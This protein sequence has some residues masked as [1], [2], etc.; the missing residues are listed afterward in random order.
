MDSAISDGCFLSSSTVASVGFGLRW[1][2]QKES[3]RTGVAAA[4]R[5]TRFD[6]DFEWVRLLLPS[7]F[8]ADSAVVGV[9]YFPCLVP[10]KIWGKKIY[11]G[12]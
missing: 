11:L 7:F 1:R 10:E 3:L 9:F 4:L 12:F 5:T 2:R 8:L 6:E